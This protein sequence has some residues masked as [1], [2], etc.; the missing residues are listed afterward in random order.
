MFSFA[1]ATASISVLSPTY[2]GRGGVYEDGT[3][4]GKLVSYISYV[5]LTTAVRKC[6]QLGM[7]NWVCDSLDGALGMNLI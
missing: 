5:V 6:D 2:R 3:C 7:T 4:G 1:A